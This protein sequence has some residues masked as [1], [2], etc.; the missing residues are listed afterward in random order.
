MTPDGLISHL[1]GLWYGKVGNWKAWVES[2]ISDIIEL[3]FADME[4]VDKL[5]LYGNSRYHNTSGIIGAIM[6]PPSGRLT[7]EEKYHNQAM[8][9]LRIAVEHGFDKVLQL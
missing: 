1:N 2:Y 3:I 5:W 9:R 6:K 7:E 4:E 8:A